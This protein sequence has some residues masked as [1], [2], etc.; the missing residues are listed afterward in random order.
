MCTECLVRWS[1]GA[2]ALLARAF[3]L[4]ADAGWHWALRCNV[5]LVPI[6]SVDPVGVDVVAVEV[7]LSR[8]SAGREG[9]HSVL[10]RL[11]VRVIALAR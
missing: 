5:V 3:C 7:A 10:E 4:P 11:W 6:T 8:A 2:V 1:S 9:E